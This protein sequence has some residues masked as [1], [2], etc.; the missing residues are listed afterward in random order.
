VRATAFWNVL[1]GPIQNVTLAAPLP[2]GS[3]RQRQNLGRARIR[4]VEA[5]LGWR[6]TRAVSAVASYTYVEPVVTAAPGQEA[7]VGR[8]LPQD[9]RHRATVGASFDDPRVVTASVQLRAL[10]RQYEDD[11]N[12]LPMGAFAVVDAY[13]SREVGGGL[14]VFAAVENLFDREYL[15]GRAGV[16]TIGQPLTV[17]AGVHL[18]R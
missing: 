3:T 9:P 18:R 16:D 13:V 15:V 8:D 6:P 14:S 4:G 1:D 17:R 2:D 12:T 7:L 11:L 5:E 10:G